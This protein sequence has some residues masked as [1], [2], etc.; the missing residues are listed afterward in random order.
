[1]RNINQLVAES[2]PMG[3]KYKKISDIARV[4]RGKR[5]IREHLPENG[6]YM[7]YQNSLKPLGYID[8]CNYHGET[9]FVIGAGAAGEIGYSICD[10]WAA[11]DCYPLVCSE[12][13]DSRF[14]YHFLLSQYSFIQSHVRNGSIPRLS[15]TVIERMMIPVPPIEVQHEIV[16]VLDNFMELTA[17]LTTDLIAELTARRLQYDYYRDR[18]F[19]F[20]ND[21]PRMKLS[22][23]GSV[24]MC[25]RILK[26]QTNTKGGI[27][28]YKIGTFGKKPDAYISQE[29]F[30]EYKAKYNYPQKGDVLISAAGTIGRTVVFDGKPAYFQ[31]SNIVWLSHDESK[32]LNKYLMYCYA[33]APWHISSG[34][35]ISRLYN[36]NILNAV[37]PVPSLSEQQRIIDILDRFDSICSDVYEGLPAE[38]NARQKQYEYYRSQL[39]TFK[40]A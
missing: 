36:D 30:E 2:C 31:D 9:T 14:V 29:T 4:E 20:S 26:S 18:L 25:K 39:L 21:V 34:G 33:R 38:I 16:R 12:E 37:I 10:F 5:V 1:M 27:P 22:E 13:I 8:T 19:D 23:I 24:C 7:V 6:K 15:R 11:D 40:E 17:K 35:T 28:F 32:V 3:V